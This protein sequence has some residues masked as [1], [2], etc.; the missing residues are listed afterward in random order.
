MTAFRMG[1]PGEWLA[2]VAQSHAEILVL[3]TFFLLLPHYPSHDAA[4]LGIC[5]W[6]VIAGTSDLCFSS[7]SSIRVPAKIILLP[8]SY[9][10]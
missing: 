8:S 7:H 5:R 3:R 9:S 6:R 2:S 1:I 4:L 10:V